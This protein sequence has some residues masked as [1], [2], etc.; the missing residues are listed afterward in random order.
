M[1]KPNL[2][3]IYLQIFTHKERIKKKKGKLQPKG[4]DTLKNQQIAY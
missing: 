3:N 2:R 4:L 1:I